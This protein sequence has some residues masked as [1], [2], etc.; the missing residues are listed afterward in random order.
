HAGKSV[1]LRDGDA[2]LRATLISAQGDTLVVKD[3]GRQRELPLD[4]LLPGTLAAQ[5]FAPDT[6]LTPADDEAR[7]LA[8]LLAADASWKDHSLARSRKESAADGLALL[9]R[10]PAFDASLRLGRVV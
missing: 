6:E 10:R 7:A 3:G 8:W 9:Q 5:L 2:T 1:E 4:A